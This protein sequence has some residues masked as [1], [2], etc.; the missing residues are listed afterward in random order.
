MSGCDDLPKSVRV[1]HDTTQLS[2]KRTILCRGVDGGH[3]RMK[4]LSL[5]SRFMSERA[6]YCAH[7]KYLNAKQMLDEFSTI[8]IMDVDALVRRELTDLVKIIQS[9]DFTASS[10]ERV[11]SRVVNKNYPIF[12]EGVIGINNTKTSR[13]FFTQLYKELCKAKKLSDY[14]IDTDSIIMGKTFFENKN[15][16]NYINLP[17]TYKD[18]EF[19]KSSHIW[20]GKGDRKDNNIKYIAEYENYRRH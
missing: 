1:I 16:I 17:K 12:K 2:D 4:G 10:K 18:T 20:S 13:E 3:P 8:L 15:S 14:D 6:C 9:C 11:D 7:A 5:R 19:N